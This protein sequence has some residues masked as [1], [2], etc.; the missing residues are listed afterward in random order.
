M[1]KL[2]QR[3]RMAERQVARRAAREKTV[4]YRSQDLRLRRHESKRN[5]MEVKQQ[6]RDAI[7]ARH[8]DWEMGPLAPRRTVSTI[9]SP[10]GLQWGSLSAGRLRPE[11]DLLPKEAEAR[12]AWAGGL[13]YLC[14]AVN[15]RVAI[16]EGPGKGKIGVVTRI[17]KKLGLLQLGDL[18]K[19]RRPHPL[20]LYHH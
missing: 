7:R 15:D 4:Q 20:S 14:L 17:D 13:R 11:T 1:D 3:T 5:R 16:I 10:N 12:C 6:L 19:V 18:I 9:D 2:I 8:E